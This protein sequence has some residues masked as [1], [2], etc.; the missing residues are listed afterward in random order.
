MLTIEPTGATLGAT[1]HG[2]DLSKP[3]SD[4]DFGRI[5][6]GL[7]DHAVHGGAQGGAGRFDGQHNDA[8]SCKL[9]VG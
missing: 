1:V 5:L 6:K 2:A 4:S 8:P 3:L 9:P 7:G